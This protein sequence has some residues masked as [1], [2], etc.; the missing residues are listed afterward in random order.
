MKKFKYICFFTILLL[1]LSTSVSKSF[2][3]MGRNFGFGIMLG[4]PT[5]LTAKVW[6]SKDEAWVFSLGNSYLGRLRI[7]ADYLWH[8]NAFNSSVVNMYAG[9]GFA[10]GIGESEGWWYHNKNKYYYKEDDEIGF[11]VR[12]VFGI[13]IVPKRTPLEIYGEIG[14]MVGILPATHTNA[15]GAIGIRFYFK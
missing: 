10:V 3:P 9:P 2:S 15:E 1:I 6:S 14:V 4:E 13:N 8:F 7:G 12:G 5:G 11:G